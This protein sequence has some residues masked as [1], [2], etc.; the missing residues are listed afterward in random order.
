MNCS[1]NNVFSNEGQVQLNFLYC[2]SDTKI[3]FVTPPT[4]FRN[5]N[6]TFKGRFKGRSMSARVKNLNLRFINYTVVSLVN[7]GQK[8]S[9]A[10]GWVRATRR[11]ENS[12]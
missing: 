4:S 8:F 5:G 2:I 12:P 11:F 1:E 10:A 7:I 9:S 6:L 3:I